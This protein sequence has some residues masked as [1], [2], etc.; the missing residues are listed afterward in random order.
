MSS[1][2]FEKVKAELLALQSKHDRIVPRHVWEWARKNTKSALWK[3]FEWNKDKA[4]HAH[5]D[6]TARELIKTYLTVTVVTSRK[7]I[8]SVGYVRDPTAEPKEQRYIA[9]TS[10][11]LDQQS[12]EKIMLAELDRC[13]AAIERARNVVGILDQRY[14]GLSTKLEGLLTGIIDISGTFRTA[15]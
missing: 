15:A 6:D 13:E 11:E 8:T 14:R 3:Q 2:H 5:W 9:L 10:A 12:A 4:A 7:V 1:Q